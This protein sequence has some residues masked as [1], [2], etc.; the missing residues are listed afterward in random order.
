MMR[1][2][3]LPVLISVL[4]LL[5]GAPAFAATDVKTP[6][7]RPD[8]ASIK[9]KSKASSNSGSTRI[10]TSRP[11]RRLFSE[12]P[13]PAP[14]AARAIGSYA[15][16]CLAGGRPLAVDGP[17]WQV[18][19]LSRNRYWGHPELIAY[20]ERLAKD[21]PAL[22]WRGLMVGDM[23]QPRGGPMLTGHSSH[24]IGLDA[25]I[26]LMEMPKKRLSK[27][28]REKLTPISMLKKGTRRVDPS[29][30]KDKHARLIKRAA[31]DPKV[32][33]IFVHPGIK[34]ALCDWAGKDRAFLRK[35]RPWY[36]HHYHFH[37]RLSCPQG[38]AGCKNQS[39]PP[40][41]DGCGENLSWW[42]SDTP[43]KRLDKA[44]KSKGKRREIMM[45][46]LPNACGPVLA[47]N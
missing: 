15:R 20:M 24:Q 14:L 7:P 32:A 31:S 26:W 6:K 37:I 38:A 33:R 39:A 3:H 1:H 9:K 17:S 12:R 25:D 40:K 8:P 11:A 10:D 19:R 13:D 4:T 36:G 34:K 18:I 2:G 42:L 46:D 29:R 41:G 28:Q 23:T 35:I 30:W 5:A 47:A 21:S 27:Q 44:K 45:A 43:W 16:G 22:G